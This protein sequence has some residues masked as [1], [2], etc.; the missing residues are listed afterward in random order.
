MIKIIK[1]SSRAANKVRADR[2]HE[3]GQAMVELAFI[4]PLFLTLVLGIIEF[5]RAMAAKQALTT[6][7]RE[8]ARILVLPYGAGLTYTT[9]ADVKVAAERAVRA[10]MNSS[11]LAITSTTRIIPIK[12]TPARDPISGTSKDVIEQNY[13]NAVR[14]D[15]VGFTISHDFD[16]P[17]AVILGFFGSGQ[18]NGQGQNTVANG[19]KM[20]A[21]CLMSHE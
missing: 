13:T 18:D 4:L 15:R 19:F 10:Y 3:L 2:C 21:T 6:A 17:L 7:A 1:T 16:T 20:G 5:S 8:G 14:G 12:V 11:G 9:E